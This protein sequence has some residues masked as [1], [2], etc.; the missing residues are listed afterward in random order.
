MFP[1]H[2]TTGSA[3]TNGRDEY[4]QFITTRSKVIRLFNL[5]SDP[6]HV[7]ANAFGPASGHRPASLWQ[8]RDSDERS[9]WVVFSS[10]EE[11]LAALG[12]S[13]SNVSIASASE[14]VLLTNIDR[15]KRIHINTRPSQYPTMDHLPYTLS[16]NPPNPRNQS[17]VFR[18]GDWLCPNIQC[19]VHNFSRNVACISCGGSRPSQYN[20]PQPSPISPVLPPLQTSHLPPAAKGQTLL[21]PAGKTFSVGGKVQ[22][23]SM[24]PLMPCIVFWPDNEPFPRPTQIRPPMST[25]IQPPILNTG[26]KGPIEHQPG[27]WICECGYHNWRRRKVFPFAEGNSDNVTV[28]AHQDRINLLSALLAQQHAAAQAVAAQ[29][30]H[31]HLATAQFGQ[32]S[33]IAASPLLSQFSVLAQGQSSAPPPP[34]PPYQFP[35][36]LPSASPPKRAHQEP[37]ASFSNPLSVV[38][39]SGIPTPPTEPLELSAA[40]SL[41]AHPSYQSQRQQQ[42][43]LPSRAPSRLQRFAS[44]PALRAHWPVSASGSGSSSPVG[45]TLHA[46]L[47]QSHAH[48]HADSPPRGS[49][50][51]SYAQLTH[52]IPPL[53]HSY[54]TPVNTR[55]A[56]LGNTPPHSAKSESFSFAYASA[57]S[58]EYDL[59]APYV[60]RHN[61]VFTPTRA[62]AAAA[63][64]AAV[65]RMFSS[66]ACLPMRAPAPAGEREIDLD[67]F[68]LGLKLDDNNNDDEYADQ[69]QDQDR[70]SELSRPGTGS[71]GPSRSGSDGSSSMRSSMDGGAEPVWSR[72]AWADADEQVFVPRARVG[73]QVAPIGSGR[74]IGTGTQTPP[75][76]ATMIQHSVS[77]PPAGNGSGYVL[78]NVG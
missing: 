37:G 14:Q 51:A 73:T 56:S 19:A 52:S 25:G 24:D 6:T 65:P 30:Q 71:A 46:S 45:L 38:P 50:S 32:P 41:S 34:R 64:A 18:Q 5:P 69:D 10:H 78:V 36:A 54:L 44:Q 27:D 31:A 58:S 72:G 12:L 20:S 26:N 21:T 13:G 42:Q 11:A 28:A 39:S 23:V 66:I 76:S 63:A 60:P 47:S 4:E 59:S 57:N 2:P 55:L 62:G 3:R 15:L 7:L 77:A 53:P 22:N 8:L 1:S 48:A 61:S 75:S 49:L 70:D 67:A 43:Q 16:S 40:G 9:A 74:G 35:V 29:Q 33:P 68:R 17:T